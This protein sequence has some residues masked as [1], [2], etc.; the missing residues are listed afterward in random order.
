[1]I[2]LSVVAIGVAVPEGEPLLLLREEAPGRRHLP[3]FLDQAEAV[4]ILGGLHGVVAPRPMTH[5]LFK[6]VLEELSARVDRVVIT[7][8][9]ED[10][11]YTELEIFWNEHRYRIS[12][13][14]SDA[15][16]LAVRYEEPV[17][18]FADETVLEEAAILFESDDD[19]A[20]VERFRAF[21]DGAA[22][23]DFAP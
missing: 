12:A 10:T 17:P 13:C 3:I 14:P 21:L 20:Q 11:F 22:P 4:A 6:S 19:E 8:V 15:V 16:A 7:E 9:R 1:M 2:R 23:E 5:D 18:I